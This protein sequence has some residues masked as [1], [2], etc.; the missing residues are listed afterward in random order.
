MKNQK[1]AK[2][3]NARKNNLYASDNE[4][5]FEDRLKKA[6]EE[7]MRHKWYNDGYSLGRRGGSLEEAGE[8]KDNKS[9]LG[10]YRLGYSDYLARQTDSSKSHSGR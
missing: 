7:K 4:M 8:L 6:N 2:I 9:F 1:D 10:G 3:F 5:Y